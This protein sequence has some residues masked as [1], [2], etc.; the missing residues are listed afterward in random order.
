M[1]PISHHFE[2]LLALTLDNPLDPQA[3]CIH[4]LYTVLGHV[5]LSGHGVPFQTKFLRAAWKFMSTPRSPVEHGMLR[6]R[7]LSCRC[8]P[9]NLA[10]HS[11]IP[12][13]V[14]PSDMYELTLFTICKALAGML[15]SF[16]PALPDVQRRWPTSTVDVIPARGG[17]KPICD[18][19]LSW[20]VD[21]SSSSA[22]TSCAPPVVFSVAT[23][24]LQRA[25][26]TFPTQHLEALWMPRFA[27]PVF[28]CAADLFH[29]LA[30]HNNPGV[31]DVMLRGILPQ[32]HAIALG[33]QAHLVPGQSDDM[34]RSCEWFE[35]VCRRR[36][37]H[38][39]PR[40][41]QHAQHDNRPALLEAAWGMIVGMRNVKCTKAGCTSPTA[42]ATSR[43][44]SKC[45][46]ARYCS[47]EHQKE[48]WRSQPHPH[49]AVCARINEL[50][51]AIGMHDAAEWTRLIHAPQA[52][53]S[54][55]QFQSLC[56]THGA[57]PELGREILRALGQLRDCD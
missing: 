22:L 8:S 39:V 19:L 35:V 49:K 54:S 10:L 23:A 33:M 15:Q 32:M 46:V 40:G 21:G 47:S 48:A 34:R 18:A 14:T 29:S 3:C 25:L 55:T 17:P 9:E 1:A 52:G 37:G 2:P 27:V 44:C 36:G 50:R 31:A 26:D 42:A 4:G 57:S 12:A 11:P 45:G 30:A 38:F 20:V 56:A 53:R 7:L 43:A 41:V 6:Q 51:A 5:M 28:C 13:A 24:H 16:N